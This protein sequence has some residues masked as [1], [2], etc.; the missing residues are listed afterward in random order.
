MHSVDSSENAFFHATATAVRAAASAAAAKG[1]AALLEPIM[2]LSVTVEEA[3]MGRIS[4]DLAT[5]RGRLSGF[6]PASEELGLVVV[7]AAVP[8]AELLTY[9]K[10]LDAL[11]SGTG[12]FTM[13]VERYE[14]VTSHAAAAVLTTATATRPPTPRPRA[15]RGGGKRKR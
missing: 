4:K 5:R 14:E 7:E 13:A 1:H 3:H 9:S 2:H 12:S 10:T 11:T 6:R 15:G 8:L